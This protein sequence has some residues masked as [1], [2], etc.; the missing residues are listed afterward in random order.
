MLCTAIRTDAA[1]TLSQLSTAA[2]QAGKKSRLLP[3][4]SML[5]GKA[6]RHQL[7][8]HVMHTAAC[9]H[10]TALVT[11]HRP[12]VATASCASGNQPACRM[13]ASKDLRQQNSM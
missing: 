10:T 6:R 9:T 4:G 11:E 3:Q 7:S 2:W 12:M 5:R 1:H 13:S 8:E